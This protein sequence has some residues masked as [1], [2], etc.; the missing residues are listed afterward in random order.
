MKVFVTG[1]TGLLGN[2]ILRQLSDSGH[3]SIAL[4]RGQVDE[5]VF[6]GINAKT[7]IGD[8]ASKSVIDEA[9]KGCDATI[10]C[11]AMIHLGWKKLDESM[12]VNR[13]STR[14]IVQSCLDHNVKLIQV[15]TVNSLAIGSKDQPANEDTPLDSAPGQVPCSYVQSKRAANAEVQAGVEKGLRAAIVHPGFMLGPWDWKPSSGRMMKTLKE[16]WTPF[17]PRG[18]CSVCDSRDVAA[19]TIA[20]IDKGGDDGR[21]YILAGENWT[22]RKLWNEMCDRIGATKPVIPAGPLANWIA[23]RF[24]DLS[25]KVT[26]NEGDVNSAS[27]KMS[28]QFHWYDSS[29]AATELGYHSRGPEESLDACA[30]WLREHHLKS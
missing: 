29:R 18:G 13:E 23:A 17:V 24:G 25:A 30:D 26:G 11:A 21:Q 10:H 22:Y 3:E 19:A 20:A 9:I 2:T 4:V 5:K 6:D 8:L 7:V 15:G 16:K 28:T 12:R 1:G 27:V 14:D